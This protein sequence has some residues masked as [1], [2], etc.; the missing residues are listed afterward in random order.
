MKFWPRPPPRQS[1][2]C[3]CAPTTAQS[4][5]FP[6]LAWPSAK[7]ELDRFYSALEQA[8][9]TQPG[10]VPAAVLEA[11]CDDLNTPLALSLMHGLADAAMTG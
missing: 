5:I 1:A 3:F 10:K 6:T 2:C 11:L 4:W 7:R 8:P 9:G